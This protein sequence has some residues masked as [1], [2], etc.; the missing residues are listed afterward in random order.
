MNDWEEKRKI[1]SILYS[2]VALILLLVIL[3]L[4]IKGTFNLYQ[5]SREARINKD[6]VVIQLDELYQRQFFLK[7]GLKELN[8]EKGVESMMRQKFNVKK[9]GEEVA[10]IVEQEGNDDSVPQSR[11]INFLQRFFIGFVDI[12][13]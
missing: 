11:I 6:R 4:A 2:K 5:K 13:R 1:R 3:I 8:S 12:F 7:E 9:E 10:I